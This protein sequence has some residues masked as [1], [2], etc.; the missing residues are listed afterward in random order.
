MEQIST[1]YRAESKN[2]KIAKKYLRKQ[3]YRYDNCGV[4]QRYFNNDTN[5]NVVMTIERDV[6]GVH[7]N[8]LREPK[9]SKFLRDL[10]GTPDETYSPDLDL[11][12]QRFRSEYNPEQLIPTIH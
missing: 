7:H 1:I 4:L 9:E 3:K 5:E 2:I 10:F 11:V 6:V 8:R 12:E